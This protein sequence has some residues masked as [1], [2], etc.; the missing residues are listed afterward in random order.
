MKTKLILTLVFHL[1]L[2]ATGHAVDT[3]VIETVQGRTYLQ[4]RILKR[5]PDGVSFS[6]SHGVAKVLYTDLEEPLRTTLGFDPVKAEA[7]DKERADARKAAEAARRER[8]TKIV[9]ALI[10]AE[11][12]WRAQQPLVIMQPSWGSGMTSLAPVLGL[13]QIGVPALP[14]CGGFHH[15]H[16]FMRPF[17]WENVGIASI[18]A[19]T[20]GIYVPQSGGF[21]FTGIP[22]AHYSPT[23]GYTNSL[24]NSTGPS[25]FGM[26]NTGVVPGVGRPGGV[27]VPAHH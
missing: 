26:Q 24:I 15:G 27:S 21:V 17:G 8:R 4:C 10:A 5:D 20:G 11:A 18:G 23:L 12:R 22:G 25:F 16:G 6:H 2:A 7:Y 19:G 3:T 14:Y 1:G 9:E 13:G